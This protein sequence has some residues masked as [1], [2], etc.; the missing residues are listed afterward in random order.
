M[1]LRHSRS[2]NR[3]GLSESGTS[4]RVDISTKMLEIARVKIIKKNLE[5][6]ITLESG[7]AEHL[8]FE[9]GLFD[10]VM[11][12]FGAR[13]FEILNLGCVNST[14]CFASANSHD[15]RIFKAESVA[16]ETV[17]SRYLLPL[18]GDLISKN[19]SRMSISEPITEF[20]MAKNFAHAC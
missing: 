8:R 20:R 19:R 14:V 6:I 7:E 10:V 5:D 11:T 18:L 2:S 9:S 4:Y 16:G 3:N 17:L 13:N 1:S 15:T 12:A